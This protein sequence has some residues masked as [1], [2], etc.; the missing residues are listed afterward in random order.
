MN[1]DASTKPVSFGM[2]VARENVGYRD[3]VDGCLEAD[4]IPAIEHTWLFDHLL[5]IGGDP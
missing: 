1:P 2:M 5:P 3:V 4:T